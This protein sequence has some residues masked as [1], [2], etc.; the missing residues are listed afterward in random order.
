MNVKEGILTLLGFAQ[1]AGKLAAGESAVENF[2]KKG[3]LLLLV[4]SAELSESRKR[5]W[6]QQAQVYQVPWIV[7]EATKLELGLAIGSS[8]RG[9]I[10]ILDRNMAEAIM[11]KMQD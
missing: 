3:R 9:V 7:L 6:Q 5:F 2:L 11:K 4:I 10:G 8:P 1:K